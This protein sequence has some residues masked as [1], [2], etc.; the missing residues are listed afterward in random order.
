MPNGKHYGHRSHSEADLLGTDIGYDYESRIYASS[1][2]RAETELTANRRQSSGGLIY[3]NIQVHCLDVSPTLR[4]VSLQA[5]AGDLFA[6]MATSHREGTALTEC[7]A[8]LTNRI[9]GEILVN[10]Q[11]INKFGLKELCGFVPAL[12]NSSLD[13]R[14]SVQS[15]L[16]FHASLR[17]PYDTSDL[18]ERVRL[19]FN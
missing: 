7:L 15:T 17:G 11:Q 3:P 8:G 9:G 6:I 19:F 14:M 18:K 4:G 10:G 2:G 5:K 12:E 1:R 16:N 13:L